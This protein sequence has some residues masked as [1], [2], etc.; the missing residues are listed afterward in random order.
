MQLSP[1][2]GCGMQSSRK[3]GSTG[4]PLFGSGRPTWGN[5]ANGRKENRKRKIKKEKGKR[6]IIGKGK[7]KEEKRGKEKGEEEGKGKKRKRKRSQYSC[8]CYGLIWRYGKVKKKIYCEERRIK[9]I[10]KRGKVHFESQI[11]V[12]ESTRQYE[13]FSALQ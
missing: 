10:R 7:G 5:D 2:N 1:L 9:I 3:C 12:H 6:G 4:A 13:S 11:L 8:K